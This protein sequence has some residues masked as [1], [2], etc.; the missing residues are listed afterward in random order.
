MEKAEC[1][2]CIACCPNEEAANKSEFDFPDDYECLLLC[3][4]F[5]ELAYQC[6]GYLAGSPF[7]SK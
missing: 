1:K 5:P 3:E 4:E 2:D 6:I 7:W